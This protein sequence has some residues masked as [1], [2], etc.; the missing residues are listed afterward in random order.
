MQMASRGA[1]PA[2]NTGLNNLEAVQRVMTSPVLMALFDMPWT[3]LF[4]AGIF[5]FHPW[6][7]MLALGGGVLLILVTL[8]HAP[9][10]YR[11]QQQERA[12]H[13]HRQTAER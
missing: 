4:L 12:C 3:P 13:A 1:A 9:P 10:R 5:I 6:L 7:G 11:K 8:D 2:R